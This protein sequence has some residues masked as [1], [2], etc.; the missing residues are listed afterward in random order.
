[1]MSEVPLRLMTAEELFQYSHEPFRQE[2][3]DGRLYEMEP[4]GA[5][6]GYV[7]MRIAS[8][9]MRHVESGDL[10]LVFA[11][12]VGFQLASE[13]DTVRAPDVA[14]V[15]KARADEIGIPR[16]YW[17]GA[18]HLAVEVVSPNDRH[19]KVEGKAL[20]WLQ[21]GTGAVVVVDPTRRTATVYRSAHDIRVLHADEPLALEDVV[22][23]WS[24]P[25]GEFFA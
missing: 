12:E 2:L 25:V 14:F 5:E 21:S 19:S 8:L 1:M 4:P 7:A 6:H 11:S 24:P 10:G 23:G 18:P 17:P 9:L 15:A 3:I 20:H 22:P 16:G 13:P